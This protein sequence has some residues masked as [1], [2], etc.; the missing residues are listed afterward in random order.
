VPVENIF[1]KKY[2][3]NGTYEMALFME[4]EGKMEEAFSFTLSINYTGKTLSI[5]TTMVMLLD[6]TGSSTDTSISDGNTFKPIY[7]SSNSK[8]HK[9]VVNYGKNV[10]GY[11]YDKETQKRYTIKE[12]GSAFFDN[13]TYPYLL[14]LLP[15]NTGYSN[16]MTV[17]DF[18]P[19]NS[20]NLK[21]VRIE[22]VNSDVYVSK[23]SGEHKVWQ[24]SV[25]E[26]ATKDSFVYYIDQ[27]TRRI[28]KIDFVLRG[29]HMLFVDKEAEVK[30]KKMM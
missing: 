26:E 17:F 27:E 8:Y 28:W 11:Y 21:K 13:Y 9:M 22:G 6:T 16:E 5:Y 20:I 3:I 10:S 7:R 23:L 30:M 15:L 19:E 2:L 18:K 1:D 14:A 25:F 29:T 24:V 12:Q 4:T